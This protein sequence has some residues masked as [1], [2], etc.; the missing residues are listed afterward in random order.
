M[1]HQSVVCE[2]LRII[3]GYHDGQDGIERNETERCDIRHEQMVPGECDE[4]IRE[5]H[6]IDMVGSS[7]FIVV[8][9]HCC[10]APLFRSGWVVYW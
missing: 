6:S 5:E 9:V 8:V 7:S 4:E 10:V 3:D 2:G 1:I